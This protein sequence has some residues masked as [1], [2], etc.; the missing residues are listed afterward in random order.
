MKGCAMDRKKLIPLV[1]VFLVFMGATGFAQQVRQ[2]VGTQLLIPSSAKIAGFTSFLAVENLDS[3]PNNVKIDARDTNGVQLGERT[4][5]IPVGGKF[6]STDILSDLGITGDAFGPITVESTNGRV[7]AAVSEVTSTD[8]PGGFFPGVNTQTAWQQGYILE[9]IDTGSKGG[10]K[11]TYR[12]NIGVNNVGSATANVT[13]TLYDNSGAQ[14][15]IEVSFTVPPGGMTQRNNIIRD[16]LQ[17]GGAVTGQNGYLKITSDRPVIAWASKVDNGS[18]DPSFQVAVG[19][20]STVVS[21]AQIEVAD[22][23]NNFLFVFFAFMG[24]ALLL[25]WQGKGRRDDFSQG[26]VAQETA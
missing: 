2:D 16:L 6:R 5:T 4:T 17:S 3:Q 1:I 21:P 13:V 23:R 26:I 9:V 11:R 15:G 8:G 22:T 25:G 14:V 18:E 10:Q 20:A 24:T 7:L 12:T 19:A